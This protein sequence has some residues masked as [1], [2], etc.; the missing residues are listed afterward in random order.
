[1]CIESQKR[2]SV[3]SDAVRF[4]RKCAICGQ[5][6]YS[7]MTNADGDFY[8]HEGDCFVQYM[9]QTYGECQWMPLGGGVTDEEGGY[10]IATDNESPNGFSGTGV[11]WTEWDEE[12]N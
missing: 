11:Y 3:T 12:E 5:P 10:Y 1:M 6:V 4:E 8:A 9:N 7:G 2:I